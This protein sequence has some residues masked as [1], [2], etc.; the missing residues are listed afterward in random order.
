MGRDNGCVA[1]PW[2]GSVFRLDDGGIT[3]G[4]A[5]TP[6]SAYETKVH[7]GRIEVRPTA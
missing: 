4:P 6:Q 2:Y 5:S 1:R 3:C 7:G